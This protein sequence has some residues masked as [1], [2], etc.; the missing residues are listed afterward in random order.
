MR[1]CVALKRPVANGWGRPRYEKPQK[2]KLTME[3]INHTSTIREL[4]SCWTCWVCP[5]PVREFSTTTPF[6]FDKLMARSGASNTPLLVYLI[7][8]ILPSL[9]NKNLHSCAW[10][11]STQFCIRS[12]DDT[13]KKYRQLCS[14]IGSNGVI[15]HTA[16]G[17]DK[18]HVL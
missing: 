18:N 10:S 4:E 17:G 13:D 14:R 3:P 2:L 5:L 15:L 1:L 11:W 12:N 6:L 9:G 16:I 7:C 8:A